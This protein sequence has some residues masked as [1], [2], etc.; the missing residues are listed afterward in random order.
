M[1]DIPTT[2]LYNAAD[3]Y[4]IRAGIE[5]TPTPQF[6]EDFRPDNLRLAVGN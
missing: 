5:Y 2:F 1:T 4:A 3:I 6:M